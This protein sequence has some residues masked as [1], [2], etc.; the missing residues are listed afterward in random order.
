MEA[1]IESWFRNDNDSHLQYK[2]AIDSIDGLGIL[3]DMKRE[4]ADWTALYDRLLKAYG[5][6]G[7][8]PG[9]ENRFEV[10]A[11]AILTQRTT[12][13]NAARA[14]D[15][16]RVADVLTPERLVRMASADLEDAI[17]SAG[18]YRAKA[19]TLKAFCA[20]S[21]ESGGVGQ[22]L[23]LPLDALRSALLSIRGIGA[24][25]ADAILVYAAEYPSFIVDAYTRRLLERLGWITGSTQYDEIQAAFTAALPSD[26]GVFGEAHALIVHHGKTQ[27]RPRPLCQACPLMMYCVF[28]KRQEAS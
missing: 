7:W 26:A 23:S 22:L 1:A 24:E 20:V 19:A 16:L 17:R 3:P 6:Q 21:Q 28:G 15:A 8:W 14:V 5:R 4:L 18:F 11:G 27:C 9:R 10:I 2:A 12:W 25:T 13:V